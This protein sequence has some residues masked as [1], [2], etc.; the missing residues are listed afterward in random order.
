VTLALAYPPARLLVPVFVGLAP[1]LVFIAERPPGAEGRW[2]ATRGGIVMGVTYFGFQ[3]Y[4][5]L[6]ALGDRPLMAVLAFALTVLVLAGLT[7]AFAWAVHFTRE[8]LGLP[9]V[10]S[11]ALFWTT[12]EWAQ[13][14][15]GELSVPWLGLGYALAP[16]PELAG[17]AELVGVRGLTLWIAAANGLLAMALV[18][19]R[20][21]A[22]PRQTAVLATALAL[23]VVA[24][25]SYGVRRA[26]TLDMRPAARV[27]V[28]QPHI[29]QEIKRDHDLAL[30]TSLVVLAHLTRELAPSEADLVAW[31]EVA[32]TAELDG[33]ARLLDLVRDLSRHAQAP[34]LAGAYGRGR[35]GVYLAPADLEG[36]GRPLHN[37]AFLVGPEGVLAPRYD[38]RRL[39]P[40]VERVPLAGP[41]ALT[42]MMGGSAGQG[43]TER[44]GGLE[45][46]RAGHLLSAGGVAF[47]VLIC[48]ESIFG[49][50]ARGYRRAGAE[51][52]V[53][54]TNDAW[55]SRDTWYGHTTARWQH[56]AHLTLRAI[57]NR[58]GA[59]RAA[60][61]G[62]SLF[63]DPVGR[64]HDV[65]PT[66]GAGSRTATVLTTDLVTLYSRWGDW[67]ASLA[68]ATAAGVLGLACVRRRR[69]RGDLGGR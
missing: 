4:W 36:A 6:V 53:N 19:Y 50:L 8:R 7:G 58:M 18:G 22:P 60:N 62:I 28:V 67:L 3:L 57:E 27:A 39:V 48:S 14:H 10:L 11:A 20:A 37:S 55:F 1:L 49:D 5:L 65:V 12:L 2:S 68:A 16:F 45:P 9:L 46:G 24:P 32:L 61:T 25:A 40:F 54:I 47:G 31:P 35:P 30:D 66:A 21:G 69:E 38:K 34:I 56:P 33:D 26:A 51:Y 63:V 43:P 41:A 15:A 29:A 52:L 17:A 23:L 64:V 44:Y 59:A 42:R 13:G